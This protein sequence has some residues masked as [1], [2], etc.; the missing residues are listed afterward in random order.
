[1]DFKTIEQ[2]KQAGFTGFRKIGDL[3]FDS[4]AIPDIKGV[5]MVL[6]LS[7][8]VSFLTIGTGGHFKG[9]NPNVS[10]E[11]LKRNW[12]EDT[13]VV[14]IG[15]AGNEGGSATLRS[16]LR[17]YFRFGQGSNVGHWG[18]RYIWQLSNSRDLVI[19]WKPLLKDDPRNVEAEM[20]QD[21]V[22]KYR[23]RPFANLTN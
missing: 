12:V 14:Y 1:M 4:S 17:Q 7:K 9:K 21:F 6:N 5:Y 13:I 22:D 15:K 3:F 11:E 23:K 2:I 20:I 10:S 8:N 16:R 18:G 19:C